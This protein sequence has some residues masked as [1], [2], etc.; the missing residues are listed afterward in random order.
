MRKTIEQLKAEHAKELEVLEIINRVTDALAGTP[1]VDSDAVRVCVH[2]FKKHHASVTL[3]SEYQTRRPLVDAVSIVQHFANNIVD[4]EHWKD[5]CVSTWPAEINGNAKKESAVLDGTHAVEIKVNGGRGFGPN[6]SVA[7]W[8]HLGGMLCEVEMPIAD[9]WPLVPRVQG[10]YTK[11]GD[12]HG[13]IEWNPTETQTVDKFRSW[14]SE[15]PAYH[16][17][18]YLADVPN[19]LAWASHHGQSNQEKVSV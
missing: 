9:L 5:G 10:Q 8:V 6:V 13:K 2:D 18:Y 14:Y 4:G 3:W 15:P 11:H 16:G 7:F 19:F 17:S 1:G 12:F